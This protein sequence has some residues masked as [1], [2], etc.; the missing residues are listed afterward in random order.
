MFVRT[1][2]Q[3]RVLV[4]LQRGGANPTL[5]LAYSPLLTSGDWQKLEGEGE[6]S[7][8]GEGVTLRLTAESASVWRQ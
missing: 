1:Y 8:Q 3:E 5:R 6:L 4:A 2:Q 7:A